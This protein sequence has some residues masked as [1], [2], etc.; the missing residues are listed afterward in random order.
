MTSTQRRQAASKQFITMLKIA[1]ELGCQLQPTPSSPSVLRGLCPFHDADTLAKADT[2]MVNVTTT[3]FWCIHCAAQGNPTAFAARAWM[4]TARDARSLMEQNPKAGADRPHYAETNTN[5]QAD[6]QPQDLNTAVLTRATH[7]YSA[8]LYKSFE[9]LHFLAR[10]GIHPEQA[11]RAG[12]GFCPGE[13]LR[14]YLLTNGVTAEEVAESPL[15]QQQTGME[16][17]NGRMTLADQDYTGGTMWLTSFPPD[18]PTE[19]Y[20]WK[21][22]ANATMGLPGRKPYLFNATKLE[23]PINDLVLTDDQRLYIALHAASHPCILVTQRRRDRLD[24][25]HH[26]QRITAVLVSKDIKSMTIAMH[27]RALREKIQE[28]L[29]TSTKA[30]KAVSTKSR[31]HIMDYLHLET[32]NKETLIQQDSP[33]PTETHPGVAESQEKGQD[34]PPTEEA[35]THPPMDET[36][37]PQEPAPQ[38]LQ[39]EGHGSQE[40]Q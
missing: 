27:D 12:I 15:F 30:P 37:K 40:T 22:G 13:G 20:R 11:A 10:L 5:D 32:R 6:A 33:T 2:L 34:L 1:E 28:E 3:R 24:L 29:T 7:F 18:P 16:L 9:P 23:Q 17:F 14:E 38:G 39:P 35:G 21:Q 19:T 4:V 31:N 36:P 26:V 8:Q 25:E